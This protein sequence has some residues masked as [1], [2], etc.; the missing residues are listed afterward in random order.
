MGRIL[1]DRRRCVAWIEGA[2][3]IEKGFFAVHRA[4]PNDS[5]LRVVIG[6]ASMERCAFVPDRELPWRPSPADLET[7]RVDVGGQEVE[8]GIALRLRKALNMMKHAAVTDVEAAF[9]A[10]RMCPHERMNSSGI[11]FLDALAEAG[12]T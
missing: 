8:N 1:G 9:S 7:G 4:S 3:R 10:L 6:D 2:I 5:A 11:G 12:D